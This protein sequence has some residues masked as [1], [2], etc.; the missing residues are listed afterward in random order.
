MTFLRPLLHVN[1]ISF[2]YAVCLWIPCELVVNTYRLERVTGISHLDRYLTF[3]NLLLFAAFTLLVFWLTAKLLGKRK[4]KHVS[5]LLWVPYFCGLIW[6]IA[7]L[8][9]MTDPQEEPLG[10]VGILLLGAAVLYPLYIA[11][12]NMFVS[13]IAMDKTES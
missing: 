13:I 11:V 5:L 10:G 12:I 7:A 1:I 6:V 4:I 3:T 8:F 2:L 9:P